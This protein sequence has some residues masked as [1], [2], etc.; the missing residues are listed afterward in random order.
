MLGT[1]RFVGRAWVL[2][3][4]LLVAVLVGCQRETEAPIRLGIL[5]WPPYE[6]FFLARDLGHYD[7]VAVELVEYRTPAEV[8]RAYQNEVLDGVA[9]TTDFL[10]QLSTID[11]DHRAV[12]VIDSSSGGD[13]L[14]GQ[15]DISDIRE[16]RGRKIGVEMSTLGQ[17]MLPRSLQS[18]DLRPSD[19]ELVFLDV[20]DHE[21]A[22]AARKVEAVVTYEPVRTQLLGQGATLLFDSSRIPNEIVD[23]LFV[24]E[25]V[26]DAREPT[27]RR[28]VDGYFSALEHLHKSP[29]DA[30]DRIAPREKLKPEEF[31]AALELV[32]LPDRAENQKLLGGETPGLI[33]NFQRILPVLVENQKVADTLDLQNLTDDRLVR[34]R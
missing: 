19:V 28:V 25:S 12:L 14:L 30:A 21:A 7:D 15:S 10:L 31:L 6:T 5:V 9:M 29:R 27:L 4:V 22:F 17:L 33:S 34:A 1:C 13:V 20:P 16:L 32:H 18:A 26:L 3:W 23:V 2:L 8:L 24:R 11:S